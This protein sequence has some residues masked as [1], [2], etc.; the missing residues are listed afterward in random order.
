MTRRRGDRMVLGW[1]K[2][3]ESLIEVILHRGILGGRARHHKRSW[4]DGA[5][6]VGLIVD[7]NRKH[8]VAPVS[9]FL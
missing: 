9:S 3:S 2:G 1:I 5:R 7:A 4:P 8:F 6:V